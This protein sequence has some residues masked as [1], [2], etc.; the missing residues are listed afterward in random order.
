MNDEC[1][2]WQ[3]A[4]IAREEQHR[5]WSNPDEM[6][7]YYSYSHGL[8]AP[9]DAVHLMKVYDLVILNQS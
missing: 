8:Y 4:C 7:D 2:D 9:V 3:V 6:M 5:L 1:F